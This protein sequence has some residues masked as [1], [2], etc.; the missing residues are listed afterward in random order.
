MDA[1]SICIR[2]FEKSDQEKVAVLFREVKQ[3]YDDDPIIA[4]INDYFHNDKLGPNGDM[5]D[6]FKHY[7]DHDDSIK[8]CFWVAENE[9][10]E[11]VGMVGAIPSIVYDPTEYIEVVRMRV[12]DKV[13]RSGVGTALLNELESYGKANGYKYVNLTTLVGMKMAVSFYQHHNY[14]I[15]RVEVEPPI[16]TPLSDVLIC[17]EV[18]HLLKPL[19]Q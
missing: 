15:Q 7:M 18:A 9:E 6:I 1:P 19:Q 10:K 16:V 2:K 11:I 3:A 17:P 14:I 8:K 4:I 13:R 5:S 12:S